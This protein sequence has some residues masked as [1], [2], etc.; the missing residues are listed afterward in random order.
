[1]LK[2]LVN[3][4]EQ[5]RTL[6]S[7]L[8]RVLTVQFDSRETER[9]FRDR[10]EDQVSA[11]RYTFHQSGSVSVT[12]QVDDYEPEMICLCVEASKSLVAA[13]AEILQEYDPST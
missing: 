2:K 8:E 4:D 5:L 10:E 1:M 3:I 13:C 11:K 6:I 9:V 7:R 12:G